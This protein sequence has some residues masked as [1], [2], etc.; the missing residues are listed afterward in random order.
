MTALRRSDALWPHRNDF[1]DGVVPKPSLGDELVI[2][3][4]ML[5]DLRSADSITKLITAAE[6]TE[7][8]PPE[9]GLFLTD[10]DVEYVWTSGG[11]TP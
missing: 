8:P 5:C 6:F 11:D 1:V 9:S 2:A 7:R 10:D 4:S 3:R